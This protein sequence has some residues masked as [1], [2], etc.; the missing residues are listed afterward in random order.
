MIYF[1]YRGTVIG[2]RYGPGS[3]FILLDNVQCVGNETSIADCPHAGWNVNDCDHSEDVSVSCGTSP[4]HYGNIHN[5]NMFRCKDIPTSS[6]SVAGPSVWNSLPEYLRDPA[7]GK[8]SFR[9]QLKTFL[10]ATY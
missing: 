1:R 8:D 2:T 9:K 10:F 6:F 5:I 4:V 7:V 3:G